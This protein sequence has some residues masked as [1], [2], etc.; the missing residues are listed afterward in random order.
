MDEPKISGVTAFE[1]LHITSQIAC[2][3]VC[4]DLDVHS[5]YKDSTP[6]PVVALSNRSAA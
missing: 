1:V 2:C 6:T 5:I 4:D 3:C